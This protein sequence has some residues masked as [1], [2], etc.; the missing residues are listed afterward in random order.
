[1][2]ADQIK[3]LICDVDGVMTDGG[4]YIAS[5]SSEM[6]RFNSKDGMAVAICRKAGIDFGIISAGH[7]PALVQARAKQLKIEHVSVSKR[8]KLEVLK[9]WLEA[10]ALKP[11]EIAYIGDDL[12][13]LEVMQYVGFGACPADAAKQVKAIADLILE[14]NGGAGCVRELVDEYLVVG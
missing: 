13:D 14:K 7:D 3:M 9:E 11:E 1:M 6:K 12:T 4:M 8:P 10:L 2:K 5:N